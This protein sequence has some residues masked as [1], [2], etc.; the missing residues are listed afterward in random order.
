M[1]SAQCNF[2]KFSLPFRSQRAHKSNPLIG[3]CGRITWSFFF[4]SSDERCRSEKMQLRMQLCGRVCN[5]ERGSCIHTEPNSIRKGTNVARH[6]PV[7]RRH[8]GRLN[9]LRKRARFVPRRIRG[10]A[11][12]RLKLRA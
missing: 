11:P 7:D 3:E 4:E 8:L 10:E 9:S 1:L 12:I 5:E 2:A 6:I